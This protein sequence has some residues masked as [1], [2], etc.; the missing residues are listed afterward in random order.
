LTLLDLFS[1]REVLLLL[2][3]LRP[4]EQAIVIAALE[5]EA[6]DW[7]VIARPEQLPPAT[8]W[9]IWLLDAGRGFGKTRTGAETAK[10]WAG[11]ANLPNLESMPGSRGAVLGPTFSDGRD[12]CIEGESGLL[13]VL[14]QHAVRRWNRTIGEL[15]LV[16][17]TH[18]R[19]FSA[20]E[21][22]RLRGHQHHWAWCDELGAWRYPEAWDQLQFTLR[23]GTNPKTVVTTTP[24]P[25]PLIKELLRRDTV[26]VTTGSTFDNAANLAPAALQELK[27]KY[28]GTRLGRQ[29]L[30]AE[31]LTD[32]PGALWTY[33]LIERLRVQNAPELTRVVVGVDPAVTD[34]DDSD[35][36]GIVV[37]AKGTDGDCYVLADRSGRFGA[38]AWARR[39]LQAREDYDYGAGA[40]VVAEDNNGGDLVKRNIQTI[41]L[42]VPYKSVH[43]T[44]QP[45][46]SIVKNAKLARAVPI[47]SLYEQGRVH[48][49]GFHPALESQMTDWVPDSGTSPDRLDALVWAITELMLEKPRP[50]GVVR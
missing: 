22:E 44:R 26:H 48:H 47:S 1:E 31:L 13:A 24:R 2:D 45:P 25:T 32:T 41:E 4:D 5:E 20:D 49:V 39:V 34:T 12:V 42:H 11:Y 36:T 9:I 6:K 15:D 30:Y 28:G 43:A 38:E 23:L 21:P 19:V 10:G 7:N 40:L 3:D 18:I 37:V 14:P 35:E 46:G 29:E 27:A 16:N 33:D 50:R 8:D 17:G